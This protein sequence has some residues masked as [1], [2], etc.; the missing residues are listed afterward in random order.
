MSKN[1]FTT[2]ELFAG[3]GGLA[4]GLENAG[5]KHNLLLEIDKYAVSTLKKNRP[6]WNVV[7]ED[8]SKFDFK[9]LKADIVTGG[10]P[11]QA[12]SHAGKKLGF[13]DTRG[14]LFLNLQ[15]Q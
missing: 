8:I 14:T 2:I 11:C 5:L 9:G 10:F 13:E 6:N 7:Q 15:G 3:A 1:K 12:F 4:L